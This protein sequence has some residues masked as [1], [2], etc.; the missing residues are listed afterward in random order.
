ME[1]LKE[2]LEKIQY[3]KADQRKTDIKNNDSP[4]DTLSYYLGV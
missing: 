3:P 2:N 4:P 1:K